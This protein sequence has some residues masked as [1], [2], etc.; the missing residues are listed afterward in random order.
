MM[1]C[2]QL[3]KNGLGTTYPNPLVGSVV[4]HSNTII[5]EGWHRA[6]GQLHAEVNAI[7]RVRDRSK[8]SNATL[9]VSLE[10]CSHFGKTPPCADLIIST[11]I[12]QVI[13]GSIDPNP[14]VAGR[15]IQKLIAAG[16]DVKVGVLT[17][18]CEDL[19]KRFY[20]YHQK[21][22]PYIFL[23]WAQSKDGFIAP[24]DGARD[25]KREP[26][27]ISNPYSRKLVHKMRSQEQAILVGT[28]TAIKD[29]PSLTTRDWT[30]NSPVRVVIDK[31]LKISKASKVYNGSLKTIILTNDAKPNQDHL[32]FEKVN[33]SKPLAHQ[34]CEIL[35]RHN[36]QSLIVEGGSKTIQTFIDENLWDEAHVFTGEISLLNGCTAPKLR[37]IS[38]SEQ[39]IKNDHLQ[40]F[41]NSKT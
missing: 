22:R 17:E 24:E 18:Q 36:L 1:R 15:G 4:V 39:K 25:N 29:N 38:I 3:A 37:E 19:N 14:K 27:W 40:I 13:I 20:S 5:G 35:H 12:K 11:G 26:V 31:K 10:P 8:L 23:K 32:A 9:Y 6:T 7:N 33:F 16:C 28:T 30:G 21:E 41:K 34:V 2:I